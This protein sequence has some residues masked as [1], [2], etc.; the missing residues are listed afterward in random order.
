[1]KAYRLHSLTVLLASIYNQYHMKSE[2]NQNTNKW[3]SKKTNLNIKLQCYN[4]V[5]QHCTVEYLNIL[6]SP[7]LKKQ[8]TFF[9]RLWLTLF[10]YVTLLRGEKKKTCCRAWK[11]ANVNSSSLLSSLIPSFS[12]SISDDPS[13]PVIWGL[14]VKML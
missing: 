5:K 1:M 8:H 6:S 13:R 4:T 11:I 9:L 2:S 3:W 12:P 10:A 14:H 7:S